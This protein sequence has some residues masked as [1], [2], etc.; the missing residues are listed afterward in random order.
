MDSL[1]GS[2]IDTNN[3]VTSY[4]LDKSKL[5]DKNNKNKKRNL[6]ILNLL[7]LFVTSYLLSNSLVILFNFKNKDFYTLYNSDFT[8]LFITLF[9]MLL[10]LAL[11]FLLILLKTFYNFENYRI[12]RKNNNDIFSIKV[13]INKILYKDS[14]FISSLFLNS[15]LLF[16]TI[17]M[18]SIN[19]KEVT[20]G[21]IP[22]IICIFI[23]SFNKLKNAFKNGIIE[24]VIS[25]FSILLLAFLLIKSLLN[26]LS[27]VINTQ[28]HLSQLINHENYKL[29]LIIGIIITLI[30]TILIIYIFSKH[31]RNLSKFIV[32]LAIFSF[33]IQSYFS[34]RL[35]ASRYLALITP[36]YDFGIFSQMFSSM[37]QNLSQITTLE[38]NMPLSHFK[39][40][41]SPIY[42]LM[43]PIYYLFKDPITLQIQQA[44]IVAFGIVPLYLI[45]KKHNIRLKY[46]ALVLLL[47]GF[48]PVLVSSSSYD[49]HENAFLVPLV[50][51]LFYFLDTKKN[52]PLFIT[53]VLTLMIKE[54]A[55]LYVII[56]A[57][58][59]LFDR[60]EFKKGLCLLI[61]PSIYFM[62][63]IKYL[64]NYGDGAMLDRFINMISIKDLS[65]FSMPIVFMTNP[66]YVLKEI[67]VYR[68]IFYL[69]LTLLPFAFIPFLNKKLTSYILLAPYLIMNLVSNYQYQADVNFQYNY[70]SCA[71]M[72][73]M[74]VLFIIEQNGKTS[75]KLETQNAQTKSR[76]LDY[77]LSLALAFSLILSLFNFVYFSNYTTYY[78]ENKTTLLTMK[79]AMDSI[80]KDKSVLAT[81]FLTSYLSDRKEI[82]DIEYNIKGGKNFNAD[83]VV[84]DDRIG[85]N[86]NKEYYLNYY[87]NLGY[88]IKNNIPN[89]LIILTK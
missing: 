77:S 28:I 7:Y 72:I 43:L 56:F 79:K 58:Y 31:E 62:L 36:S 70:G 46:K 66:G 17:F 44:L 40:H 88:K 6:N 3:V 19:K 1:K 35:T 33:I 65:I 23:I 2:S 82:Y 30:L 16:I 38:R 67:F 4:N 71:F 52:I 32:P 83:Y 85:F 45:L 80:D 53:T 27:L 29:L 12:K 24:K 61:F 47:F 42:Y 21:F 9:L 63:S 78:K 68:K 26:I 39:V 60:K 48:I 84:I 89:A 13:V 14:R 5:I 87:I 49:L 54:D 11:E 10:F 86:E 73:Y 74:V 81:T 64:K 15:L 20:E 18:L 76:I 57:L 51:F 37:A 41:I 55:A 59:V 34:I 75:V 69:L 25:S 50:L 22:F 8:N